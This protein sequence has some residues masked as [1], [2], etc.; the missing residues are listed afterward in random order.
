[1]Y[2]SRLSIFNVLVRLT[3]PCEREIHQEVESG[4]GFSLLA[5]S[6][7][8]KVCDFALIIESPMKIFFDIDSG[9][10]AFNKNYFFI[11]YRK[12]LF[13]C[14]IDDKKSDKWV[15]FFPGAC[16]RS[17][18]PPIFQRSSYSPQIKANVISLFD[19]ALL[20]FKSLT[21][22]WF[23]GDG[24]RH[25]AAY[26]ARLLKNFFDQRGVES[27]NILFYGTSAG[28]IP[29]AISAKENPGSFLCAGNIQVEAVRHIA[30]EKMLPFLFPGHDEKSCFSNFRVRFDIKESLDGSFE[31]FVFQNRSDSFHYKNHFLSLAHW[32]ACN[33]DRKLNLYVYDNPEA[34]H[35]AVERSKELA[36][37]NNILEFRNPKA[38][39]AS[40]YE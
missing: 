13:P 9:A 2:C 27:N 23:A 5:S 24:S 32:K 28:G 11:S 40:S 39:W 30:F 4:S 31:S 17:V 18:P 12:V 25:H 37:I 6:I 10:K 21:N 19:P 36:L 33:E 20:L 22:A 8:S 16:S 34:G 15:V 7:N 35:G 38:D 29:A 3:R 26:L 1:M 14:W